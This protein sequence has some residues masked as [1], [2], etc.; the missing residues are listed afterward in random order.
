MKIRTVQ[1]ASVIALVCAFSG[2][3]NAQFPGFS[4]PGASKKP[5]ATQAQ[6]MDPEMFLDN[7]KVAEALMAQSLDQMVTSL[8]RKEDRAQI[9]A[10]KKQADDTTDDKE[11][12]K[13]GQQISTTETA[14]LNEQFSS[15]GF[16]D[17]AKA[18]SSEERKKLAS[19]AFN[20]LLALLKDEEL[21]GQ[22]SAAINGLLLNPANFAK[23]GVIKDVTASLSHQVTNAGTLALK[24]PKI[25]TAVGVEQPPTK[26][27]DAPKVIDL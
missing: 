21:V 6:A 3:A 11:K 14:K 4:I 26:A 19:S 15:D 5:A 23:V 18:M 20:F 16:S 22:S 1:L 24:V 25:F 13:I 10:L 12:G 8:T 2:A 17:K 9:D 7:V 27:S